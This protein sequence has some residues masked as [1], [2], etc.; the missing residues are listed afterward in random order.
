ML[1]PQPGDEQVWPSPR[2]P[3]AVLGAP[4]LLS[5]PVVTALAQVGPSSLFTL[6]PTS[7]KNLHFLGSTLPKL[8]SVEI[9][10]TAAQPKQLCL[11]PRPVRQAP[12]PW[13]P[14]GLA[15]HWPWGT[16][17]GASL[18]RSSPLHLP[19]PTS[20]CSTALGR[21]RHKPPGACHFLRPLI[22]ASYHQRIESL[23]GLRQRQVT[24]LPSILQT[25]MQSPISPYY[26][27]PNGD[28]K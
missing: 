19:C 17:P 8:V 27:Q 2:L 5:S 9:A 10:R 15:P 7:S 28:P 13:P 3:G 12:S 21:D 11:P 16:C 14:P 1:S 26:M 20:L 23:V 24:R 6:G 25:F 22:H 4:G 18:Q